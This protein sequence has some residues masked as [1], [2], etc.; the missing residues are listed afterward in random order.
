M[1]A[2]P[3]KHCSCFYFSALSSCSLFLKTSLLQTV[4]YTGACPCRAHSCH[5]VDVDLYF[6]PLHWKQGL[7]FPES[8]PA[9]PT[10]RPTVAAQL[11]PPLGATSLHIHCFYMTFSSNKTISCSL[12]TGHAAFLKHREQL[13]SSKWAH[14]V[15]TAWHRAAARHS[16]RWALVTRESK[17]KGKMLFFKMLG[18][19]F[20]TT[21][22]QKEGRSL[23]GFPPVVC[24]TSIRQDTTSQA[25]TP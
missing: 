21:R 5:L 12:K 11:C 2:N 18:K 4:M 8:T 16:K 3:T 10:P 7:G 6:S 15:L 1:S 22:D 25:L 17:Q 9:T 14:L 19:C 23:S 20:D 24:N 13:H